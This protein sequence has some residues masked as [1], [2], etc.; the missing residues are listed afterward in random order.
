[1]GTW[2]WL[3]PEEKKRRLERVIS[4]RRYGL[5]YEQIGKSLGITKSWAWYLY[6]QAGKEKNNGE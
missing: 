1:L 5:T 4:L 3:K 2:H 6:N